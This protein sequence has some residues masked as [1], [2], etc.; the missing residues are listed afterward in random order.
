VISDDFV[1]DMSRAFGWPED[2]TYHG[3]EGANA[4]LR[5]WVD[6]FDDW[7]FEIESIRGAGDRV[8]VIARQWGRAKASGAEVDMRYG[9]IFTIRDGRGSRMDMY[10]DP[11]DALRAAEI[12][13]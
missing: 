6:A 2:Q 9:Q 11:A 12:E 4:F 8:V 5:Q 10:T 7:K 1:W 13:D 3:I